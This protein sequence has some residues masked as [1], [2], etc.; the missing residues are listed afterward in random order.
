MKQKKTKKFTETIKS[1]EYNLQ[2][3]NNDLQL[4]ISC[5]GSP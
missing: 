4:G 5:G 1:L 3:Y 2:N